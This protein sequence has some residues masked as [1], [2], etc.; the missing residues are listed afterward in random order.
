[1]VSDHSTSRPGVSRLFPR[2]MTSSASRRAA[3]S[4][5]SL[6]APALM[7]SPR[8]LTPIAPVSGCG[9]PKSIQ[10]FSTASV[11]RQLN[12]DI[13]FSLTPI[14]FPLRQTVTYRR[15]APSNVKSNSFGRATNSCGSRA[16]PKRERSRTVQ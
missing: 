13:F 4:A 5:F 10:T 16:A 9:P 6:A 14:R 8:V 3:R 15:V 1:M 7:S 2:S 12:S 11:Q